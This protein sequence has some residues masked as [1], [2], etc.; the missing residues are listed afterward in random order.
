MLRGGDREILKPSQLFYKFAIFPMDKA[1]GKTAFSPKFTVYF[2]A[3][4]PY[5]E[6]I[7]LLASVILDN[8]G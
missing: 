7:L 6:Y 5:F 4:H 3:F 8:K 2:L 1:F